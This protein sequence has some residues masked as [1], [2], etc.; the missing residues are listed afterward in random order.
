MHIYIK[1]LHFRLS[2]GAA[3]VGV[4]TASTPSGPYTYKASW[5][6]LGADSRDMGLYQGMIPYLLNDMLRP[7]GFRR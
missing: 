1:F 6:P 3:M 7:P 4:A 2:Y 5:Q